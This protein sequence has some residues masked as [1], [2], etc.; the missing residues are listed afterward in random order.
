MP[1]NPP[2]QGRR[3]APRNTSRKLDVYFSTIIYYPPYVWTWIYA[4]D[5]SWRRKEINL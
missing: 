2:I 3:E 4:L 1:P 5:V